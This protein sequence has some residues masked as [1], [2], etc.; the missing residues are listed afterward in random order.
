MIKHKNSYAIWVIH[1]IVIDDPKMLKNPTPGL[2]CHSDAVSDSNITGLPR[3]RTLNGPK[4]VKMV[5]NIEQLLLIISIIYF[6]LS[7]YY[8]VHPVKLVNLLILIKSKLVY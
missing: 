5:L 4:Y 6:N 7:T 1:I 8:P 3:F 2:K